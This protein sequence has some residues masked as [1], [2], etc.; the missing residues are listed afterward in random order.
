MSLLFMLLL[1]YYYYYYIRDELI[2]LLFS[3]L[4]ITFKNVLCIGEQVNSHKCRTKLAKHDGQRAMK[5][6]AILMLRFKIST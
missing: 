6:A 5:F 2:Y 3:F 4:S 1:H